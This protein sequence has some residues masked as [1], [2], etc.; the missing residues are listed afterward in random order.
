M[1]ALWWLGVRRVNRAHPAKP[2]PRSRSVAWALGVAAILVALDS[3]I[4]RYDTSLFWVHMIQHL[5]LTLVAPLFSIC[6]RVIEYDQMTLLRL[7]Q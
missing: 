4:E 7:I 5:L 1:L 3:G 2:V 6:S